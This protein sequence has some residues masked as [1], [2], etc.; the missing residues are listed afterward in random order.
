MFRVS[1]ISS[2][3]LTPA[4]TAVLVTDREEVFLGRGTGA[5]GMGLGELCFNTGMT[6]YQEVMTDPSYRGQI[7]TFTFPHIGITGVNRHDREHRRP[8]CTGVVL[9]ETV[10]TASNW[11]SEGDLDAWMREFGLSGITG[12]DTRA[13]TR[14]IQEKGPC[15]AAVFYK[16]Q[17][18]ELKDIR[19]AFKAA[20]AHV[21]MEGLD[22]ASEATGTY[23]GFWEKQRFSFASSE[24]GNPSVEE[25]R[26]RPSPAKRY[27]TAKTEDKQPLLSPADP[28]DPVL[29]EI[30]VWD[31]GIKENILRCLCSAGLKPRV[32]SLDR[33]FRE[34]KESGVDGVF[35]S[36]GPGDPE[37]V[38]SSFRREL[39]EAVASGLPLFGICMGHQLLAEALGAN[40]EKMKRG[41]RGLNHPVQELKTGKVLITSQ[42]HGFV[43]SDEGFPEDLEVTHRSLFDHSIEGIALKQGSVFSVQFHPEASPGPHEGLALFR[44][45]GDAVRKARSSRPEG[46]R[47][48][49]KKA[50][51]PNAPAQRRGTRA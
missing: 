6:G 50:L 9:R 29:P 19:N 51:P 34:L 22:L 26:G 33:P 21:A 23:T 11:R 16:T 24:A 10:Q 25:R 4:V 12:P 45:F 18:I 2:S 28:E 41:H 39:R 20:S 48:K 36:N 40:I 46:E 38:S 5:P 8:S 32:F 15:N 35:L 1:E 14:L 13:L 49:K 37:A 27:S 42:N 43:V 30:A 47:S 31:Y 17:G 3:L 7:I 44:Q